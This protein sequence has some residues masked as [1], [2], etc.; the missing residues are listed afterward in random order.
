V[1]E[2]LVLGRRDDAP[3][4]GNGS[5]GHLVEGADAVLVGTST[6]DH[7]LAGELLRR[8]LADLGPETVLAVDACSLTVLAEEPELLAPLGTRAV[9]VPNPVEAATILAV[10]VEEV[11]DDPEAATVELVARLGCVVAVR[12]ADTVVAAPGSPRYLDRSGHPALGT[13]GS[14]DVFA[15]VLTGLLAR[16]TDVLTATLWAVQL[17]GRAGEQAAARIGGQGVLARELLDELPR[18]LVGVGGATV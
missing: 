8:V 5:L 9:V 2:A 3:T 4:A 15:G 13:S 11:L 7:D 16:G 1:P 18:A 6:M 17:H 14:G 10:D 12:C